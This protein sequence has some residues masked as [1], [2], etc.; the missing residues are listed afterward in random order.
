M[1]E[2]IESKWLEIM[3]ILVKEHDISPVAVSTWIQP[4]TVQSVTE[5][6]VTFFVGRGL[7][8]IEFIKHKYYDIYISMAIEQVTG[9]Q[10][11]II[12]TDSQAKTV[13]PKKKQHLFRL[14]I[15]V[16]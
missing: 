10:F 7:R 13:I 12:F 2:L 15:L 6:T 1:K 4:L 3:D 5:D 9:Q 11:K 14:N 16:I 8:G